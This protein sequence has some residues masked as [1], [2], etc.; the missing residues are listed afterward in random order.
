M[1]QQQQG[2]GDG[3]GLIFVHKPKIHHKLIWKGREW[4]GKMIVPIAMAKVQLFGQL[5][6]YALLHY[7]SLFINYWKYRAKILVNNNSISGTCM[8]SWTNKHE[9][10]QQALKIIGYTLGLGCR[11]CG[12]LCTLPERRILLVVSSLTLPPSLRLAR[13]I[14]DPGSL[15]STIS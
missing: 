9:T 13:S 3:E 5:R 14:P 1:Q 8:V 15:L 6:A 2:A 12:C 7:L 10:I 11:Q 4:K